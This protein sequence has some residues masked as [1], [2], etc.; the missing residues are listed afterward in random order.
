MAL[1][2][3]SVVADPIS[4]VAKEAKSEAIEN[5]LQTHDRFVEQSNME[6][7][8]STTTNGS[9]LVKERDENK[10]TGVP[11]G[12]IER[13]NEDNADPG[14]VLAPMNYVKTLEKRI[15]T[16]AK[17]VERLLAMEKESKKVRPVVESKE[18]NEPNDSDEPEDKPNKDSKT[19]EG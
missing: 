14:D 1:E 12:A 4:I 18:P 16:L 13:H 11:E 9:S 2:D 6:K 3:S 15:N 7:Q 10:L 17:E 8:V 19:A 5:Q